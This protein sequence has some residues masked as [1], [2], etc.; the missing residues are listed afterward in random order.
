MTKKK[1][2]KVVEWEE[3][4]DII[5]NLILLLFGYVSF[6]TAL[7]LINEPYFEEIIV[8]LTIGIGWVILWHVQFPTKKVY[9]EEMEKQ[10]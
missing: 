1:F 3:D 5:V 10:E 4:Y 6:T 7:L 8:F 9:Y 2:R